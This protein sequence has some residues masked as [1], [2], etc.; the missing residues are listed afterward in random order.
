M[1][2]STGGP[3]ILL[4]E[5]DQQL[6]G[7]LMSE[8]Q[9]AGFECHSARTAVEVFDAIARNPIRMVL[10]N[11][12][13]AAASRREFWVALD[14]QRRGRGV[15]V[16]T[17]HCTNI[18]SYG[19]SSIEEQ[20]DRTQT[21]MADME[22]EG[23]SGIINMVNAVRSQVVVSNSG[24][25]TRPAG[26]GNTD[27][28]SSP[29]PSSSPDTQRTAPYPSVTSPRTYQVASSAQSSPSSF[30]SMP[31]TT[32]ASPL[33][34]SRPSTA[35]S[36]D[37]IRAVIYPTQRNW[38]TS[39]DTGSGPVPAYRA[40]PQPDQ[41]ITWSSRKHQSPN[42]PATDV[43]ERDRIMAGGE[44]PLPNESGL[45]QLS[46]MLEEHRTPTLEETVQ[47]IQRISASH[48]S[49]LDEVTTQHPRVRPG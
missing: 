8:L 28:Y 46:R 27:A 38:N 39:R 31:T 13:Q 7:L 26:G 29:S 49:E 22:I 35:N 19:P 5:R 32:Q 42:L 37:R 47:E 40:E 9:L 10:V 2:I 21:V 34:K 1:Q 16:F 6:A 4:F 24:S 20:D 48:S 30:P 11:L 12:A 44:V 33:E 43:V 15:Q 45:A 17:Y 14:T 18:A 3:H 23:M 36:S 25:T 41:E